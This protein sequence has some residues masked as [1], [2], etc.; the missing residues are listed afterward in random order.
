MKR[1]FVLCVIIAL[2]LILGWAIVKKY[3]L[4][5]IEVAKE[6]G[7]EDNN[8]KESSESNDINEN[9]IIFNFINE[10][11]FKMDI[12]D[13]SVIEENSDIII[14][15][16]IASI[17]GT[18]NYNPTT[19]RYTIP[20]TIGEI[21]VH[22]VLKGSLDKEKISF[23]KAGGV[24]SVDEYQKG[25]YDAEK[26]KLRLDTLSETEKKSK[27]VKESFADDIEIETDKEYL[28]YLTYSSNY[29]RYAIS[30]M[31]FGLREV[32]I[33]ET[34]KQYDITKNNSFEETEDIK[35]KNNV[36][37]EWEDLDSILSITE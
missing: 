27:Y 30:F 22:K 34:A 7:V 15:G 20:Q 36:T 28:M 10:A 4:E 8:I 24:I 32:K 33:D 18:I 21:N 23:I 12:S 2:M 29:D 31:Q 26:S 19:K 17:D 37:N 11:S 3:S 1:K 14:I 35:V 6:Y 5:E 13:N 25:L 16:N 9:D